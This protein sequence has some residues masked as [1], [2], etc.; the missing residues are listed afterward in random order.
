[1]RAIE[2]TFKINDMETETTNESKGDW[3]REIGRERERARERVQGLYSK[4]N[5]LRKIMLL[6]WETTEISNEYSKR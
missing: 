1:M 6:E 4:F 3:H 2:N 5:T